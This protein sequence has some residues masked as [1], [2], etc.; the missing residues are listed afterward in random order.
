MSTV[1]RCK[2]SMVHE[3]ELGMISMVDLKHK[4]RYK[5]KL[6]GRSGTVGGTVFTRSKPTSVWSDNIMPWSPLTRFTLYRWRVS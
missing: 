3:F 5:S 6:S 1:M 2:M 4:V